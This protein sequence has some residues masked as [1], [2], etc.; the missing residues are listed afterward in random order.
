M[1][2][3]TRVLDRYQL[4]LS[5]TIALLAGICVL[6]IFLYLVFLM[7]AVEHTAK[8]SSLQDSVATLTV[9]VSS[10]E[11]QYLKSVKS[12]SPEHAAALGFVMPDKVT[13][14]FAHDDGHPLSLQ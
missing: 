4:Y 13:P 5:R 12:L 7:L 9:E 11:A 2:A 1:T 14:V 8:R 10:L 3:F 6:S